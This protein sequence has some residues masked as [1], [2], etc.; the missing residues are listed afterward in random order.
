MR[1]RH[2]SLATAI[3]VAALRALPG[4]APAG[5]GA[6]GGPAQEGALFLLLPIGA[7]TVGTGQAAVASRPGSEA[8]W[9]NP[10]ALARLEKREVALHHG[11]SIF[12]TSDAVSV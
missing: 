8:A 1:P 10:S 11:Q 4:L 2:S 12:G 6:Q 9:W 3:A 7:R 5:V